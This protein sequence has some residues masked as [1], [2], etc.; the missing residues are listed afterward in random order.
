MD[1]ANMNHVEVKQCEN[2]Y[3]EKMQVWFEDS[4]K[5]IVGGENNEFTNVKLK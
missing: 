3:N 1:D 5:E 2:L 4:E